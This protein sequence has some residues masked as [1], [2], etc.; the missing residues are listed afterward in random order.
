[1]AAVSMGARVRVV[2]KTSESSQGYSTEADNLIISGCNVHAQLL[3]HVSKDGFNGFQD[4]AYWFWLIVSTLGNVHVIRYNVGAHTSRGETDTRWN[5]KWLVKYPQSA[6]SD[7]T[8]SNDESGN[9][10]SGSLSSLRAQVENGADIRGFSSQSYAFPLQNIAIE[11][12]SRAVAGQTVDHV[13]QQESSG[14]IKFQSRPYWW[15]TIVTSQG[16][17][18]MSR[19]TVGLHQSRG[20]TNDKVATDW[21]ADPCWELAYRHSN[22]GTALQGSRSA[23]VQ[24]ILA[25]HRVR[26]QFPNDEFY[27]IEADNLSIRNGHV[28]AQALKHVSKATHAS[29]THQADAHWRW[30]MVS[31]SGTVRVTMYNVGEHKHVG[32]QTYKYEI[33]WFV[34]SR[35]W[36]LV[37]SNDANGAVLAGSRTALV[38]AVNKGAAVRG[39]QGNRYAFSAQNLQI[40]SDGQH[41]QAQTLNHVSMRYTGN[42]EVEIQP[43]AYWWF[44]IVFTSGKRD[45]SRWSVGEHTD[46][47]H[48]QDKV[49]T[50]W[51]V[52][53]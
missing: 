38:D 48:T 29:S 3:Q 52:N 26:I 36:K 28:T 16:A 46:R 2:L 49:P 13:S 41:V 12:K 30:L 24:R 50:K 4:D 43:N 14:R 51:F 9:A 10:I 33:K 47:G 19:W 6:S 1:M 21:F 7:P 8:Y 22:S 11:R 44:T 15:F 20:H 31:T 5:V 37:L 27:T 32:D 35:P 18:D 40:S 53:Y 42:N 23:L 17:R 45:M 39:V 34:D 25:G